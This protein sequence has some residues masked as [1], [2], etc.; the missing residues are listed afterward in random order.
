MNKL[1]VR[2]VRLDDMRVASVRVVSESPEAEALGKLLAWAESRGLLAGTE[3]NPVYGFNNPNP[4]PGEK[5]Y[6]YEFWIKVDRDAEPEGDIVVK[7]FAGG[8]YAVTTCRLT[9][10]P[11]GNVMEVWQHLL[12]WVRE[13]PYDWRRTHELERLRDPY[14]AELDAVLDLYLPVEG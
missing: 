14:A 6:G 3:R 4:S 11:Q 9:G 13:S 7:D 5:E 10:D 2:M 8:L 12:N 1:D